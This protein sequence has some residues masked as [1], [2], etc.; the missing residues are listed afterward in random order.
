[1]HRERWVESI[2]IRERERELSNA[3]RRR[4]VGRAVEQI[5]ERAAIVVGQDIDDVSRLLNCSTGGSSGNASE[6][7]VDMFTLTQS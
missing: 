1:M 3:F 6:R 5:S 4:R 7:H 2:S